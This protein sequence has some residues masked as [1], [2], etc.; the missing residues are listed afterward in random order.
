MSTQQYTL[1]KI[2][3]EL[4]FDIDH[5]IMNYLKINSYSPSSLSNTTINLSPNIEILPSQNLKP[6]EFGTKYFTLLTSEQNAINLLIP[7]IKTFPNSDFGLFLVIILK[8][9]LI[10]ISENLLYSKELFENYKKEIF[11][12]YH[13][14]LNLEKKPKFLDNLCAS[15]SV[16][17]IL[18]FSGNWSNGIE[19]LISMANTNGADSGNILM[20]AL[21]IGNIEDIYNKLK[22]KL[23]K[24]DSDYL[25]KLFENYS[26]IIENFIKSL[27]SNCFNGPKENFVNGILFKAFINIL[28]LTKYF[29]VNIIK[30]QGFLDFLINCI[31]YIDINPDFINQI[32]EV[33]SDTLSNK[34]LNISFDSSKLRIS[35][36]L[37]FLSQVEN[38]SE[39]TEIKK[40]IELIQNVKNYYSQQNIDTVIK[41]EKN[42]QIL[43]AACN[44][45]NDLC[46]NFCYLF[47]LPGFDVVMQEIFSYFI[48]LPIYKVN[49]ILLTSF[50]ELAS[51]T[52]INYDFSNYEEN[53][54]EKVKKNFKDFLYNVHNSI[55]NNIKLNREE[56]QI[57][58]F[59][60]FKIP[61]DNKSLIKNLN[62]L[63]LKSIN[64]DDKNSFISNVN[65]FYEN[66]Y[67]ILNNLFGVN[68]FF[69]KLCQYLLS[70]TQDNDLTTVD[71]I[72]L[73]FNKIIFKLNDNLPNIIFNII[74]F[75]FSH[76]NILANKRILLQ[77]LLLIINSQVHISKNKKY[78]NLLINNLL[79]L[80]GD[81][82]II[83][84]IT[85]IIIL[86]LIT[87]SYQ[88]CNNKNINDEE[89][90]ALINIF[91]VLTNYLLKSLLNVECFFLE[92]LIEALLISCFYNISLGIYNNDVIYNIAEKLFSEANNNIYSKQNVNNFNLRYI[93]IIFA[94]VK[95]IGDQD[96][97]ILFN[98]FMKQYNNKTYYNII[99]SNVINI[100]N[101]CNDNNDLINSIVILFNYI[102][103]PMKEKTIN[104]FDNISTNI[105]SIICNNHPYNVKIYSLMINL[106]KN[107]FLYCKNSA[108]FYEV[109]YL[110]FDI[111][112]SMNQKY[113]IITQTAEKNLL[114]TLNCDFV[115][116]YLENVSYIILNEIISCK[117]K[118]D[119]FSFVFNELFSF[120][121]NNN[122]YEVFLMK[123]MKIILILSENNLTL[124]N[125][126]SNYVLRLS[127][128][129][130]QNINYF[131][132]RITLQYTFAVYKKFLDCLGDKFKE[133]M[134]GIFKNNSLVYIITKYINSINYTDY[135]SL[136]SKTKTETE[137]FIKELGGL[138]YAIDIKKNEFIR[139]YDSIINYRNRNRS[140]NIGL[141][142]SGRKNDTLKLQLNR[143]SNNNNNVIINK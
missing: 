31:S 36:F 33:F 137:K 81:C 45:F 135:N 134:K 65:E 48:G 38:F 119:C 115:L 15:I 116:L 79:N 124:N 37:N 63:L 108:K 58:E 28:Q 2:D 142:N 131:N 118:S 40:C 41:N 86:N 104:F 12:L 11:N 132:N 101:N 67:D 143:I 43:F 105:I 111:L 3:N 16:L 44:I 77:F 94:L 68:D 121:E 47:F 88:T 109:T 55:F 60:T 59:D 113:Q 141:L 20:A 90:S 18:G 4:I 50:N 93:Y 39:F 126:L 130:F 140:E 5:I 13:T 25:L 32:C 97:E 133:A 76:T 6:I 120:F 122:D 51:L 117:E 73:L 57:L 123:F 82:D 103:I 89:K 102:V 114:T 22:E 75:M 129:I 100:I 85:I 61:K 26:E 19:Q 17:I 9:H 46:E 56:F 52:Y 14:V 49:Q 21:I 92:K 99:E 24:K 84:Q 125:F 87:T 72:F 96:K 74:D 8:Q 35:E 62:E 138:Y 107:I 54:R 71:C 1:S 95:V 66:F 10:Q 128:A 78:L 112:K 29:K 80:K 139:E 34:N 127:V 27:I 110:F 42:V 136:D 83:N 64:D 70:S 7:F 98:F 91:D 53:E 30:I 69:D 23:D 106:Y